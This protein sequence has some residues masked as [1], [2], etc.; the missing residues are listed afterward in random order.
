MEGLGFENGTLMDV[1]WTLK[2]EVVRLQRVRDAR[3]LIMRMPIELCEGLEGNNSLLQSRRL[4]LER[5]VEEVR[6]EKEVLVREV[7]EMN[8]ILG[9]AWREKQELITSLEEMGESIV[10]L[11]AKF[12]QL[13]AGFAST[14]TYTNGV[15][16]S[17]KREITIHKL[18]TENLEK[19]NKDLVEDRQQALDKCAEQD[20]VNEL[21]NK[22][23]KHGMAQEITASL[24]DV[25]KAE[26]IG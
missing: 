10:E 2:E 12:I 11:K 9:L 16:T 25:A 7:D 18:K 3:G 8:R 15:A 4:V 17:L 14:Q 13:E 19:L 6:M 5:Q 23:I 24:N 20:Q 26:T 1:N 22:A 21:K